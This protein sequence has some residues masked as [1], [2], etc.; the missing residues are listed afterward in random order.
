MKSVR[1]VHWNP[2]SPGIAAVPQTLRRV[3]FR[4][5]H[6]PRTT[7]RN[8]K[9]LIKHVAILQF[10][11]HR[12]EVED[13]LM[14]VSS[15][16]VCS[17]PPL[18]EKA[19]ATFM[20]GQK[21]TFGHRRSFADWWWWHDGDASERK[22]IRGTIQ[23][24]RRAWGRGVLFEAGRT[25]REAFKIMYFPK[26]QVPALKFTPLSKLRILSPSKAKH[27][28]PYWKYH[29]HSPSIKRNILNLIQNVIY[30]LLVKLQF[31]I[32]SVR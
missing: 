27:I 28:K 29:L 10:Q 8:L 25:K 9:Y 13:N 19:R 31:W 17:F 22:G 6:P 5:L 32:K 14:S 1:I 2:F 7:G 26:R 15:S 18:I 21:Y 30:T 3:R 4:P 24:W 12:E 23:G 11:S 20:A 16:Q